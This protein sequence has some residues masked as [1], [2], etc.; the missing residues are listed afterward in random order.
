MSIRFCGHR[1]STLL[2]AFALILVVGCGSGGGSD[3]EAVGA[4]RWLTTGLA[5]GNCSAVV[6][7]VSLATSQSGQ[8]P[9]ETDVLNF[10][11]TGNAVTAAER[12]STLGFQP[13]G[14]TDL[15]PWPLVLPLD[16]N[17]DPYNDSNWRF[18]LNAW[19]MLDPLIKA[20]EQMAN[21]PISTTRSASWRTGIGTTSR[22]TEAA[23]T[24]GTTWRPAS[25]R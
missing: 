9:L 7:W 14:R 3:D 12:Q 19:R 22:K 4:C 13:P 25:A 2:L 20:W 17:A 21:R 1:R 16:W 24:A 8:P 5:D 6:P 10:A 11:V 23:A 18:H 15:P